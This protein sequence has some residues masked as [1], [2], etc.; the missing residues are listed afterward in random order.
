MASK[1][2]LPYYSK[3]AQVAQ[4]YYAPTAILQGSISEYTPNGIPVAT[5]Y[6]FLSRVD[7]WANGEFQPD[8]PEQTQSYIKSVYK[9]MIV[10][11]KVQ[12]IDVAG[13]IARVDWTYG[14]VYDFYQD[15]VDMLALDAFGGNVYNFY[16]KNKYNQYWKC[17]WNNGGG[18]ARDEPYFT[19]ATYGQNNNIYTSNIDGYK[20]KYMF[21]VNTGDA[22]KFQDSVW[23]PVALGAVSTST[24]P[25]PLQPINPSLPVG[26]GGVEVINVT[27]SGHS[28]GLGNT[29]LHIS[30]D[31]TGLDAT[32]YI[33]VPTG[34]I[35]D[36]VV[37]NPGQNYTWANITIYVNDG[38][39]AN[40]ATAIAPISPTAGHGSDPSS[41]LGCH[42]FMITSKF[43]GSDINGV[44]PT[45]IEYRQLGVLIN[46]SAN[47]TL[48]IIN[49]VPQYFPANSD[50]YTVYTQIPVIP[51]S[52]SFINDEII[53]QGASNLSDA[54]N[55]VYANT[56][57]T[58]SSGFIGT[59]LNFDSTN[60]VINVINTVGTVSPSL[61]VYGST[62]GTIR[63]VSPNG[64]T[65]PVII[66]FSGYISY[67]EN[68]TGITRSAD[69]IEQFKIVLGY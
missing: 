34:E 40:G 52:G 55:L 20:W 31:G 4:D 2:I 53:F 11:K 23:S 50:I 58:T 8:T 42:N 63:T 18:T 26:Y 49:E 32:A 17:L 3:V 10:A 45:N 59:V 44:V 33:Y 61:P 69:G 27:N 68:R 51:G 29:Y 25:N 14:T 12:Q 5:L 65:L 60:N 28:Y 56:L 36:I 64:A 62:S 47:D 35:V 16:V 6:V 19:P 15:N 21:T 24:T 1:A 7:P 54:E 66:P 13:V 41:E 48:Q 46:P 67:I 57:G 9:N 22:N 38:G 30:G 43:E 37:N 39:T